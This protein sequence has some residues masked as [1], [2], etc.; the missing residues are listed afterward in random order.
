MALSGLVAIS[1]EVVVE[2][3]LCVDRNVLGCKESDLQLALNHPFLRFCVGL[4][5]MVDETCT[6]A[7]TACINN[8]H[9]I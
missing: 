3:Y 6:V 4:A 1:L 5:T 7:F 2:L 8:L 9:R